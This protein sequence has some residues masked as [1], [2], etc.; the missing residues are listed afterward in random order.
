MTTSSDQFDSTH[1]L[2]VMRG[3][4]TTLVFVDDT[5]FHGN[6]VGRLAPDL[7]VLAAVKLD[8]GQYAEIEAALESRLRAL[9]QDEFH[10]AEVCNP[11]EGSSWRNVSISDRIAMFELM[12]SMVEKSGASMRYIFIS[13]GQYEQIRRDH[14]EQGNADVRVSRNAGLKRVMLRYLRAELNAESQPA[15]IMIDQD[16]A[17]SGIERD[18][19]EN[20]PELVGGGVL[21][22][23]SSQVAGLQ[24]AD[25][26]SFGIG[27]RYRRADHFEND[28]ATALDYAAIG[29]LA[30]LNGRS[31]M[32]L[33]E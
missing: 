21:T 4:G 31:R 15:M 11:K 19:S 24:I 28:R 23:P 26:L 30:A 1:A 25:A 12:S 2:S 14:C 6:R 33:G 18:R 9:G 20:A 5:D 27:R 8:S 17:R 3:P 22:A 16:R 10:G 29:P 13:D 7:R 32:V